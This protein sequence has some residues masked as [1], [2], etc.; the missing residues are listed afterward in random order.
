MESFTALARLGVDQLVGSCFRLVDDLLERAKH[1]RLELVEARVDFAQE[2]G[3]IGPARRRAGF[4]LAPG[5][6]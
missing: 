6:M 5:A 3:Q 4:A 2:V 1:L